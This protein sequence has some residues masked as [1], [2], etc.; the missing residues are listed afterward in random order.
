MGRWVGRN[1]EVWELG[2]LGGGW[3]AQS[4]WERTGGCRRVQEDL[5]SGVVGVLRL[6]PLF[7]TE[8]MGDAT[9]DGGITKQEMTCTSRK[10]R[11]MRCTA[12]EVPTDA[13][14]M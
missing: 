3:T 6:L 2:V 1:L 11:P 4:R 13:T 14:A 5:A 8:R 7:I 10:S 12:D 9:Q